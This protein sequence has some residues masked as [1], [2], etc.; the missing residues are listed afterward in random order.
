MIQ[1]SIRSITT[2][3]P[4]RAARSCA[5]ACTRAM[6]GVTARFSSAS[7]LVKATR[8]SEKATAS[9]LLAFAGLRPR[10]CGHLLLRFVL[11]VFNGGANERLQRP[12]IDLVA[13]E[14]IDRA[15]HVAF[16]A[17]VEET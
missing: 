9:R 6:A 8:V 13:F 11:I 10:A 5:S 2:T 16:E 15:S 4:M 7:D 12:F 3:A 14:K 17:G 1:Q